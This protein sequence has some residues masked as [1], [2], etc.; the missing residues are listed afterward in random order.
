MQNVV[1]NQLLRMGYAVCVGQLQVGA[2]DFVCEKPEGQRVYVQAS[3]LIAD[4]VCHLHDTAC[5][6]HRC[7]RHYPPPSP[8]IPAEGI[9]RVKSL[10]AQLRSYS[11][12]GFTST[13]QS[14]ACY[15]MLRL[16]FAVV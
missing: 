14:S 6:P 1:Y 8:A 5:H 3:Y 9:P 15:N 12:F 11:S 10:I 4:D 2:I 13:D 16:K 7:R